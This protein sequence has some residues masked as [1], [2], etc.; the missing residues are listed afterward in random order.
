[1]GY[2]DVEVFIIILGDVYGITLELDILW[3]YLELNC[4]LL[5]DTKTGLMMRTL[6]NYC[7]EVNWIPLMVKL[8]ALM[9]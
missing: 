6:R 1:M 8:L 5:M 3:I 7:V 4:D 2:T 9:K